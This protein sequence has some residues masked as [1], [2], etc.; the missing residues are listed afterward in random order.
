M[1]GSAVAMSSQ[2]RSPSA[3]YSQCIGPGGVLPAVHLAPVEGSLPPTLKCFDQFASGRTFVITTRPYPC[4]LF[5]MMLMTW[6][7]IVPMLAARVRR[8]ILSALLLEVSPGVRMFV[9]NLAEAT[10]AAFTRAPETFG[11][12]FAVTWAPVG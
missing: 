12:R 11:T 4:S 3:G 7:L 1:A 9:V 10:R 6:P 8:R 2:A 5:A